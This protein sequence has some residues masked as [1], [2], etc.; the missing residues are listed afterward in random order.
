MLPLHVAQPSWRKW[1]QG[2]PWGC[3]GSLF[4]GQIKF[5]SSSVRWIMIL[6]FPWLQE[7]F[8]E[9]A[10]CVAYWCGWGWHGGGNIA[11]EV[12]P[13]SSGVCFNGLNGTVAQLIHTKYCHIFLQ[14][15]QRGANKCELYHIACETPYLEL[16]EF[17]I[18]AIFIHK[19]IITNPWQKTS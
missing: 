17:Y 8:Y 14:E 16:N 10:L 6:W 4:R 18:H 19:T 9:E 7:A 13:R 15:S 2:R 12:R 1:T 5:W 3:W 11:I